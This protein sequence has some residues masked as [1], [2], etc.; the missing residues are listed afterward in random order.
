MLIYQEHTSTIMGYSRDELLNLRDSVPSSYRLP[1]STWK[2]IRNFG[3]CRTP[4]TH[5]GNR[6]GNLKL[7]SPPAV[8]HMPNTDYQRPQ[9]DFPCNK[10]TKCSVAV[11][12]ARSIR[13]KTTMCSWYIMENSID[14]M[15]VTESWLT[16]NPT[17]DVIIGEVTPPGYQFFNIP[18]ISDNSGGGIAVIFKEEL[19]LRTYPTGHTFTTF[20]HACFTD[21]NSSVYLFTIYRP[22]PS[23][24]NGLKTSDFLVEFV[25]SLNRKVFIAGDFNVHVDIPTK[26][27]ASDLLTTLT[28]VG[29]IQHVSGPTHKHGHTLDLVITRETENLITDCK[30]GP[31]LS[32]HH[33]IH[34]NIEM[35][36][37]QPKK[38]V[39]TSRKFRDINLDAFN[40]DLSSQFGSHSCAMVDDL[41][42]LY[43]DTIVN[44]LNKHAPVRTNLR[45]CRIRQP[46]YNNDIHEARRK[47]RKYERWW[48]K[49][50]LEAHRQLYVDQRKLVND[51]LDKAKQ[52]FY[53]GKLDGAD[54]KVVFKTVNNLLNKNTKILPAHSDS[55]KL[56][57]E[58]GSF[59]AGKV[60]KIYDA[61]E[62]ELGNLSNVDCNVPQ[63]TRSML[64]EFDLVSETDIMKYI[65]KSPAKSC[66]LDEIP[67]WFIKQNAYMFVPIITDI[68]NLSFSTGT[69]PDKLKH[70]I[71]T[72]VIKK[73]NVDAN[74][75]KNFRP[76]SNIPYL[77]KVIERHAVDNI[78]RYMTANELGEPLQSAYKPVHST[79]TALLKVKSDIMESVSHRK[80]V[81]LALLD[82][83]AAFD[84]VNHKILLSRLANDFGIYGNVLKWISS[85]LSNRTTSVCVN[86]VT[87]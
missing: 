23:T 26:Y 61:I 62:S 39:V 17:D 38:T 63:Y 10:C 19:G 76:V 46:W 65:M 52:D 84:T 6:D 47:R 77:S 57:N 78:S 1:I 74:A 40:S 71:I 67:T 64:S 15:F 24:E 50:N 21:S 14:M 59:F 36:E 41:T 51:M 11:W 2:T 53:K 75:L 37:P 3:I 16:G 66:S 32:D 45:T 70:A 29:F 85:Y 80:G 68:V 12:N 81:F 72:P 87:S 18:R 49:S 54:T 86:G 8:N 60:S 27:D 35:Y 79:E 28:A 7:S 48:R 13:H 83:S 44:V 55:S 43:Q 25:N 33:V 30:T 22:P 56:A 34:C 4:R 9:H 42:G 20:E 58:F 69:F 73:Q 5:R 82:L 31:R